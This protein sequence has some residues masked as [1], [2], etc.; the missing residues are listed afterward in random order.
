MATAET[1]V[2]LDD[3]EAIVRYMSN[4]QPIN[5]AA[6]LVKDNFAKWYGDVS[7]YDKHFDTQNVVNHAK[8]ARTDFN[9]ANAVTAEER[10][11]VERVI[12]TGLRTEQVIPDMDPQ[13]RSSSGRLA[14]ETKPWIPERYKVVALVAGV[15]LAGVFLYSFGKAAPTALLSRRSGQGST[16]EPKSDMFANLKKRIAS[17]RWLQEKT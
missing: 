6:A 4:T 8:N 14:E 7:W 1:Q 9:R 2:N 11:N 12:Q 15:G 13:A 16:P 10:A 5:T 17:H 3:L